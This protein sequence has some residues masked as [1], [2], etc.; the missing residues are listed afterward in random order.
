MAIL[1]QEKEMSLELYPT[2]S[3]IDL[4]D[5][6]FR[7]LAGDGCEISKEQLYI[8]RRF[9]RDQDDQ[10]I[11]CGCR[12]PVTLEGDQHSPC[13]F[14][15]GEGILWDEHWVSGFRS[16]V[17]GT[18][19]RVDRLEQLEAGILHPEV[20]FI[21]LPYQCVPT[22]KDV[23]IAPQI[24]T[25]GRPLWPIKVLHYWA[26]EKVDAFRSDCGRVEYWLLTVRERPLDKHA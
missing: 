14:C 18:R 8:Y 3:E 12:N 26:I 20:S 11:P 6:L 25:E 19:R 13:P 1:A 9:R 4:R 21:Y 15:F 23:I 17:R 24:D 7:T 2:R 16:R 22:V 10:Y 5:E